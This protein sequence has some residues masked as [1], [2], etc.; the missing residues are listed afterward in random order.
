MTQAKGKGDGRAAVRR[1]VDLDLVQEILARPG[2][3]RP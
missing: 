1:L 2:A 3:P